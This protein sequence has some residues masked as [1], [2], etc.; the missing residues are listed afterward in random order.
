ME[1]LRKLLEGTQINLETLRFP[2]L[3]GDS[4]T[5]SLLQTISDNPS[6]RLSLSSLFLAFLGV[7][8]EKITLLLPEPAQEQ[9]QQLERINAFVNL[10]VSKLRSILKSLSFCN[11]IN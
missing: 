9:Q 2:A 1:S 10:K 7:S 3:L 8:S 11:K 6:K 4:K 5:S